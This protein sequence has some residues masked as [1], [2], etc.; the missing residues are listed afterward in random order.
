MQSIENLTP[1]HGKKCWLQLHQNGRIAA[2]IVAYWLQLHPKDLYFHGDG[3][4]ESLVGG[5]EANSLAV[6][7]LEIWEEN[8]HMV[9][10][11]L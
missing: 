4:L 11:F 2:L 10:E 5:L 8:G 1:F 7:H 6:E 3:I 9:G